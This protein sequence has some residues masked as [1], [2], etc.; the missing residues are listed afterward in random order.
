[1][2]AKHIVLSVYMLLHCMYYPTI[3]CF[4]I[5]S[6]KHWRCHDWKITR[7]EHNVVPHSIALLTIA[8][9]CPQRVCMWN[10]ILGLGW[11]YSRHAATQ[12]PYCTRDTEKSPCEITDVL[13]CFIHQKCQSWQI[14]I[15]IIPWCIAVYV[16]YLISYSIHRPF[17]AIRIYFASI[18]SHFVT[19]VS[20]V[21]S[22][23]LWNDVLLYQ[24][25]AGKKRGWGGGTWIN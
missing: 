6:W 9:G 10:I 14:N 22:I 12:H 17:N 2:R 11:T 20:T 3:L 1:M 19:A 23:A 18:K 21:R 16:F 15:E 4:N 13:I 5:I 24:K 7:L 25:I 8:G